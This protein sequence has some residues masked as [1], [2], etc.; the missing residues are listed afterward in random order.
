MKKIITYAIILLVVITAAIVLMN[1]SKSQLVKQ[2]TPPLLPD[3]TAL[4]AEIPVKGMRLQPAKFEETITVNGVLKAHHRTQISSETGGRIIKWHVEIGDLLEKGDVILEFDDEMAELSQKQAA[5]ALESARIAAANSERD[6]N[7]MKKL[8]E[9]GDLSKSE[10][11]GIELA[12]L[13]ADAQLAGAEAAL[14]MA[15]RSLRETR[16]R[17][18]YRGTLA[19]KFVEVGQS[20]PPGTPVGEIVQLD[21]IELEISLPEDDI[22]RVKTGQ[23]VRV[24]VSSLNGRTYK[25]VVSSVG[26][27][28]D[29]ARRMF[30][31]KI[32]LSNPE[33]DLI[34]GMS[35]SAEIVTKTVAGSVIIPRSAIN[36]DTEQPTV[37]VAEND[38]AQQREII[39]GN[40]RTEDVVIS[41]GLQFGEIVLVTGQTAVKPNQKI[42]LSME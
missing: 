19:L 33:R 17:M 37:Y 5:A 22:V 18:P 12:K 28:A 1:T 34:P 3:T 32:T 41:S 11:E 24:D 31:V 9:Q 25:G 38:R 2:D 21:P 30:P 35:A 10:F 8:Y 7:R 4:E 29:M 13:G 6:Y 40:D 14:G 15:E 16:V 42:I 27:A 36:Y 26:I 23:V 39:I 20:L